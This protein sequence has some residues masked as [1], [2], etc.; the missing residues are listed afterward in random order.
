[1]AGFNGVSI[2]YISS[3]KFQ[4]ADGGHNILVWM[5]KA[6]K[7]RVAAFLPEDLLPKIATEE[8]V[9][10][11]NQ[12]KDWLKEKNHPIVETW[13]DLEAEEEEEDFEE[14]GAMLPMG[15]VGMT[16]PGVGGGGGF[17][18][19]LKNC[20]IHAESIIIKKIEPRRKKK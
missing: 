17:K 3:P 8:E 6:V 12:L 20:K 19:I 14:E 13:G 2:Q 5:P 15:T 9:T 4:Q 16:I 1:M 10:D 11:L 18:I 7:D